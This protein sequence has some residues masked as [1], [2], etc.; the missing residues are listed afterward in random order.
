MT[1]AVA[2]Q[3]AR[4][5]LERRFYMAMV[6]AVI[7]SIVLGFSR[8]FFLRPLFPGVHAPHEIYFYLHGA[9]FTCWLLLILVQA[10]LVT[11]GNTARHMQFG[12]IGFALVPLM[13]VVGVIG[14]LI[15]ARRPGGFTDIP[16]PPLQFLVVPVYD[17]A[18]FAI[19]AGAGLLLRRDRQSH[20]RLM[21][22]ATIAIAEAGVA[23]WPFEPYASNPDAAVW[24]ICLFL[25]PLAIWDAYSQRRIHPATLAG[26]VLLLTEGPLRNWL[27]QTG[28][29]MAFARW[30]TGLLG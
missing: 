24:T 7:A 19:L 26:A 17:I 1:M 16:V 6:L 9:V 15:A 8:S 30:S 10:S 20:K 18:L 2:A 21:L 25:I 13:V 28:A 22:I 5:N 4:P 29:W 12:V 11:A 14:S 3:R 27:M 23:R